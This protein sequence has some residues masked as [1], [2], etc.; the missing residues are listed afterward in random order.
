MTKRLPRRFYQYFWDV[1]PAK[2]SLSR[3]AEFIVKRILEHGQTQDVKW[4]IK[5]YGLEMIKQVLLKY[6]DFSRKT[7]LF[8]CQIIG[9][10]KDQVKCL[11]TPYRQIPCGV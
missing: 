11:Q 7:G 1:E 4:V 9:L 10:E 8:W 6:R 5:K 2:M 3:D